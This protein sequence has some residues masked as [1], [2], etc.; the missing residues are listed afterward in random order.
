MK[1]T[2]GRGTYGVVSRKTIE[3]KDYAIKKIDIDPKNG[4][5]CNV[6]NETMCLQTLN[7]KSNVIQ[8]HGIAINESNTA[9]YIIMDLMHRNLHQYIKCNTFKPTNVKQ[10]FS[11]IISGLKNIHDTK[12]I[13]RDLKPENILIN[14]SDPKSIRICDFGL[15]T[16]V[17]VETELDTGVTTCYYRAP[18][19]IFKRPE[20]KY[21]IDIWSLGCIFAEMI[22][23]EPIFYVKKENHLLKKITKTIKPTLTIQSNEV[24]YHEYMSLCSNHK[25]QIPN[26]YKIVGEHGL[27]LLTRMLEINPKERITL[28]EI[29]NHPYF[30]NTKSL[31]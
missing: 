20:Y 21:E 17:T 24:V 28:E 11:S 30:T 6:I 10:I 9:C 31:E 3:D 25:T 15:S 18:E 27:D 22:V 29:M 5:P 14:G 26:G 2:I 1:H 23:P 8:L 19:L 12:I 16:Q 4:I 7:E 13:H